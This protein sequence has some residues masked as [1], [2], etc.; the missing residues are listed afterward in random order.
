[1]Q[2]LGIAEGAQVRLVCVRQQLK[3]AVASTRVC[4]GVVVLESGWDSR[5]FDP[6]GNAATEQYGINCNL[7]VSK[8]DLASW[9]RYRL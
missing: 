5:L 2:H 7:L 3:R 9:A 1:M 4:S 6:H 8:R